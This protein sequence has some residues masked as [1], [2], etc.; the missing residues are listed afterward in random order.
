MTEKTK[1][2]KALNSANRDWMF[3][4]SMAR[5]SYEFSR[6]H[7]LTRRDSFAGAWELFW[8]KLLE[9]SQIDDDSTN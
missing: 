9:K 6:S 7:G 3:A 4:W 2:W 1:M 8:E 5:A